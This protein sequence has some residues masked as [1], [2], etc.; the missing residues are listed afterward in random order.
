MARTS[1]LRAIA[2]QTRRV[3]AAIALGLA[4]LS[5]GASA[6][7]LPAGNA[8]TNGRTLLRLAAPFEQKQ[9]RDVDASLSEID[10]DL[11]RYG[12]GA[13]K[14]HVKKANRILEKKGDR[15]VSSL[16]EERQEQGKADI[17][18]LQER[19]VEFTDVLEEQDKDL[20]YASLNR[21]YTALENLEAN[22]I[23]G[24]PFEIPAE[25]DGFPRLLGRA[26]VEMETTQGRMLLLLDGYNA[27]ITAG[28]F[29]DLV[30]KGF[31]DGSEFGQ[32]EDFFYMQAGDPPGPEDGYIDPK[33]GAK[34]VLP[35]EIRAIDEVVPHYGETFEQAGIFG[36]EPAIPFS[37]KGTLAMAQYPNEPN[38]ASSQFFLFMAEPDLSPAGLNFID[39]RYATFGYALEGTD[40]LDRLGR[41]VDNTDRILK[42]RLVSGAEFLQ[43]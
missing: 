6:M 16:L 2:K 32:I 33:T 35:L 24:F 40:V 11:K 41:E 43:S 29:A 28:N 4:V 1:W 21:V 14:G 5:F 3:T 39:G 36:S 13:A 7:A 42:A 26:R 15:I 31:Y 17:A 34:R 37:A 12:W 22:A 25:Y 30:Q 23:E 19:M 38:S 18:T 8:V 20:A 10:N 9:L 27:P